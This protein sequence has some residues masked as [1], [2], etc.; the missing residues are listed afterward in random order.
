[1]VGA[2]EFKDQGLLWKVLTVLMLVEKKPKGLF[3][4][5][6][7]LIKCT[8][9]FSF[10]NLCQSDSKRIAKVFASKKRKW[11]RKN[12]EHGISITIWKKSR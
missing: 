12:S 3:V 2:K 5:N 1:M 9:L 6:G 11:E 8:Y 7:E 4:K 10:H